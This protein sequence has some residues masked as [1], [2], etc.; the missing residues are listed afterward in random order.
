MDNQEPYCV[1][2]ELWMWLLANSSVP[3]LGDRRHDVSPLNL[4]A[5]VAGGVTLWV[6]T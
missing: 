1:G 3:G 4:D 5:T 6:A 2:E